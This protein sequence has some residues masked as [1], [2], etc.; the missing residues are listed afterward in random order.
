MVEAGPCAGE[1]GEGPGAVPEARLIP[2]G[3]LSKESTNVWTGVSGAP[4]CHQTATE[5]ALGALKV[6]KAS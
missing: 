3:A 6:A 2:G 4:P 1:D 5:G